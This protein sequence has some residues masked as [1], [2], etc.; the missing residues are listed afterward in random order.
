MEIEVEGVRNAGLIF[1][2]RGRKELSLCACS[3]LCQG[4]IASMQA[5]VGVQQV[6]QQ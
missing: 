4:D 2:C 6:A 1:Y 5:A 3:A